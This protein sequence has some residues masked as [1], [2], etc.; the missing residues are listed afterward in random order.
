VALV[1]LVSVEIVFGLAGF[2]T[3]GK[4]HMPMI[5]KRMIKRPILSLRVNVK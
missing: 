5:R 2:N 1:Q 3:L 4:I